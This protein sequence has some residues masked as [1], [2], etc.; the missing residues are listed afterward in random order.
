MD[1]PG[2]PSLILYIWGFVFIEGVI[3]NFVCSR[4]VANPNSQFS[5]IG[6][7]NYS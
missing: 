2:A 6:V 1:W 5:S 7:G 4:Q 3:Q